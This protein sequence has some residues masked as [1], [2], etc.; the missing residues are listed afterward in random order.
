[1]TTK[2]ELRVAGDVDYVGTYMRFNISLANIL[3]IPL[4]AEYLL[5]KI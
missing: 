4:G 3:R 2:A 5:I 1:M